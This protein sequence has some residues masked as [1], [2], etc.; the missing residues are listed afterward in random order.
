MTIAVAGTEFL[1]MRLILRIEGR[2][3][4]E[5]NSAN[6]RPVV[7]RALLQDEAAAVKTTKWMIEA[8]EEMPISLKTMTNGLE[9][10]S[11]RFHG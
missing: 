6:M 4:V 5:V 1:E 10:G 8:A 3:E 2:R 7:Y 9:F 11:S